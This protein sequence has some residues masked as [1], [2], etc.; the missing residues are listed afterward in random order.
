MQLERQ[1]IPFGKAVNVERIG[2]IIDKGMAKMRK[3]FDVSPTGDEFE[4]FM[5]DLYRAL[6][7]SVK[8]ESIFGSV[9]SL[10][11]VPLTPQVIKQTLWRLAGN[12]DKLREG[13]PA[14]PWLRQ[15]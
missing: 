5:L 13:I 8:F 7:S 10:V 4:T 14:T 1:K 6:P 3:H 9:M 15:E 2:K 11:G 12:L